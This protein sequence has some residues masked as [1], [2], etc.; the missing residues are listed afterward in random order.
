M[1][2]TNEKKNDESHL[3]SR[4]TIS[5]SPRIP[6]EELDQYGVWVKTGPET[7]ED[8]SAEP[9]GFE[10]SDLSDE[11]VELTSE[12]EELLGSL[13]S[14]AGSDGT[15]E[16][17][18]LEG[19]SFDDISIPES[20][21]ETLPEETLDLDFGDEELELPGESLES[22]I[23]TKDEEEYLK[24]DE[25]PD[26]EFNL[27][28]EESSL[29]SPEKDMEIESITLPTAEEGLDNLDMEDLEQETEEELPELE[30]D[31]ELLKSSGDSEGFEAP[32]E[33]MEPEEASAIEEGAVPAAASAPPEEE[34]AV[35]WNDLEAVEQEMSDSPATEKTR[36]ASTYDMLAKIEDELAAIK[37]E[38]AELKRELSGLR[39]APAPA[40]EAEKVPEEEAP[41]EEKIGFFDEDE[42]ETIALT[43]DELDNILNTADITEEKGESD[44]LPEDLDLDLH[45]GE[46]VPLSA[47]EDVIS[48]EE[49]SAMEEPVPVTT[50]EE[51]AIIEEYN[52]ELDQFG[53]DDFHIDEED[54]I[55]EEAVS[56]LPEDNLEREELM[57]IE[58]PSSSEAPPLE[59][60]VLEE[61]PPEEETVEFDLDAIETPEAAVEEMVPEEQEP[62][63]FEEELEEMEISI[64]EEQGEDVSLPLEEEIQ[65]LEIELPKEAPRAPQAA[66]SPAAPAAAPEAAVPQKPAAAAVL[67]EN[68]RDEIKSV[69][70]YMD[71]LL[72][73]L[74]E[75]KIQEFA[76][77]EHFEVYRRLFEE[78]GLE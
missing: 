73:A 27:E 69:L 66:V 9:E 43:G 49:P 33:N 11:N 72:E 61:E 39:P 77:S 13:E 5:A 25:T 76:H 30:I 10:L 52:R 14:D 70:K 2:T 67:P 34:T 38:L 22:E 24:E 17:Q 21:D 51:Q 7:V 35:E 59:E 26:L 64:P 60:I 23:L 37:E 8:E 78:L 57:E 58:E 4:N 18:D 6:A 16:D 68:V 48:L 54:A 31:E 3:N 36:T 74:P 55:D 75:E 71:Q 19:L 42:D 32:E 63:P 1:S 29:E 65:D 56:T 15:E 44:V 28:E 62:A 47:Q 50:E 12:E 20:D 41:E 45:P 53:N 40:A 46:E